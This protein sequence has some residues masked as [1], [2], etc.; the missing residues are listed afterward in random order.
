M[1]DIADLRLTN[2][3]LDVDD[4]GIATV[5]LNRPDKRNALDL[6]TVE[7]LAGDLPVVA[8]RQQ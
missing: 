1:R 8:F 3:L 2:I 5:T 4:D 7:E 6:A